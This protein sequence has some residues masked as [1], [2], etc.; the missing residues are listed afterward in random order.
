[1]KNFQNPEQVPISTVAS[2]PWWSRISAYGRGTLVTSATQQQC[3]SQTGSGNGVC[4]TGKFSSD[5][6]ELASRSEGRR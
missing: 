1:M 6:V 4:G 2:S 3:S 5:F